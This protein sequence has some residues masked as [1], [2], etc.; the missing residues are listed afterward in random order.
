LTAETELRIL[1]QKHPGS[2]PA[3]KAKGESR[4]GNVESRGDGS[5]DRTCGC[6]HSCSLEKQEES[7]GFAARFDSLTDA[8]LLP[9]VWRL[10]TFVKTGFNEDR[11]E[12][13]LVV[14]PADWSRRNET[15]KRDLAATLLSS[16]E[17]IRAQAGGD[18]S[19]A[20]LVIKDDTG[21]AVAKA[22][23]A[24]GVEVMK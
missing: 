1:Y 23:H 11:T 14:S 18:P 24:T 20:S 22:S 9:T 4:G 21:R 15:A 17:A 8:R 10:G 6:G 5:H 19:R 7:D 16:L 2:N 13:T 3:I 12:W